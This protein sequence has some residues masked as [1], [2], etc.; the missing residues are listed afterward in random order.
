MKESDSNCK[1]LFTLLSSRVFFGA[2]S[3]KRTV[4]GI[5]LVEK[6]NERE[7]VP[8]C[9]EIQSVAKLLPTKLR[10]QY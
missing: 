3:S 1:T 10:K 4:E 8:A 6:L 9:R 5:N 7:R 2:H